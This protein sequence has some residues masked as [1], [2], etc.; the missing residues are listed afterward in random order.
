MFNKLMTFSLSGL[1]PLDNGFP[2]TSQDKVEKDLA[3]E[4]TAASITAA[5]QTA[6]LGTN[7]NLYR[8]SRPPRSEVKPHWLL[9]GS[10]RIILCLFLVLFLP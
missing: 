9:N 4:S 2:Q 3:S 6:G 5:E 7:A 10:G 1:T 8:H